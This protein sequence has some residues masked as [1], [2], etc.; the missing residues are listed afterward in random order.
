MHQAHL[1]LTAIRN[2]LNFL[3]PHRIV[4]GFYHISSPI[5][6][7]CE[8]KLSRMPYNRRSLPGLRVT[9]TQNPLNL[10]FF[11]GLQDFCSYFSYL[12]FKI[13]LSSSTNTHGLNLWRFGETIHAGIDKLFCHHLSPFFDTALECPELAV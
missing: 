2:L 12:H 6:D 4:N 1:I 9:F 5:S 10:D 11:G 13:S 3:R 8:K 7:L